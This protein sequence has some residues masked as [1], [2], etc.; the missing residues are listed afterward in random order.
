MQ[1][2]DVNK[3]LKLD[4]INTITKF[5]VFVRRDIMSKSTHCLYHNQLSAFL[6]DTEQSILGILCDGYHGA[7]VF[8]YL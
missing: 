4:P 5:T 3:L 1:F 6:S 7:V 2:K 8:K